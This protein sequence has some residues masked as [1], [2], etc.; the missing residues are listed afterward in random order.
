MSGKNPGSIT[1]GITPVASPAATETAFTAAFSGAAARGQRLRP[2]RR[3]GG[4]EPE[5]TALA[6]SAMISGAGIVGAAYRAGGGGLTPPNPVPGTYLFE[7]KGAVNGIL[8]GTFTLCVGGHAFRPALR[9]LFIG[10]LGA[11]RSLL[12][13]C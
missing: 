7:G 13:P 9:R 1:N 12:Q 2:A 5:G 6:V 4:H 3:A 8:S 10:F 11:A